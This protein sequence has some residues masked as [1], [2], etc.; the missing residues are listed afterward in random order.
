MNNAVKVEGKIG[1]HLKKDEISA[2]MARRDKVVALFDQVIAQ[3][4]EAEVL[5]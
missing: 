5:Y 4:G 1:Q 2:L 3:K